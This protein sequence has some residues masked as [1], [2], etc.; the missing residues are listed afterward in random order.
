MSVV[1]VLRSF[2]PFTAAATVEDVVVGKMIW[3]AAGGGVWCV[4]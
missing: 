1:V 4:V 3:L 2:L